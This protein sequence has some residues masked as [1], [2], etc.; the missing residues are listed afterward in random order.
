MKIARLF[1][2]YSYPA[3]SELAGNAYPCLPNLT[4]TVNEMS[5]HS[6]GIWLFATRNKRIFFKFHIGSQI[7]FDT[8]IYSVLV[9]MAV[10]LRVWRVVEIGLHQVAL[11][12]VKESV[13]EKLANPR[14]VTE[15]RG[16]RS[17]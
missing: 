11:N 7:F 10:W 6:S 16:W 12:T 13:L 1:L 5:D 4:N 14:L 15:D 2:I 3:I 9:G 17:C 8:I